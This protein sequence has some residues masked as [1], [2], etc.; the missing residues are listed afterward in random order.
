[1][2][3]FLYGPDSYRRDRKKR[4]YIDEFAKKYSAHGIEHVSLDAGGTAPL[5][6]AARSRSLFEP[7]KLVVVSDFSEVKPKSLQAALQP[8]LKDKQLNVLLLA[9][10][11]PV[12]ALEFLLKPPA[13][14]AAFEHLEGAAW[15]K[16]VKEEAA[17]QKANLDASALALLAK[18]YEK[19]SWGLVTELQK[20]SGSDRTLAA[21][22]L[23]ALGLEVA[24]EF[25]PLV[26]SLRS[27]QISDRFAALARLF[28]ENEP[29][30]KVFNIIAAL[31]TQRAAHFAAY[32]RAVKMGRMDYEEALTDLILS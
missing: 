20:L 32:D 18:T 21:T 29:A 22:D 4:F 17:A 31:W 26:Q 11:K 12:K 23:A 16:F 25:F 8:F 19:D 15:N 1:M 7:A 13:T 3:I 10:K 24:P 5:E 9:E 14:S 27:S 30:P 28:R 2:V 6:M